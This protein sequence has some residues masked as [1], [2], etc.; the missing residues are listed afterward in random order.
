MHCRVGRKKFL[1]MSLIAT[2][3]LTVVMAPAVVSDDTVAETVASD[4]EIIDSPGHIDVTAGDSTTFSILIVNKSD[5]SR[6]VKIKPL[7][8]SNTDLEVDIDSKDNYKTIGTGDGKCTAHIE[9]TISA[10]SYAHQG[11]YSLN[12]V[13]EHIA[14]DGSAT[15]ESDWLSTELAL[16]VFVKSDLSSANEYNKFLG[17]FANNFD[18]LMGD[19]WFTSLVT[20]LGWMLIGWLV[21]VIAVPI[22]ARIVTKKDDPAREPL[23]KILYRMCHAIIFLNAVGRTLRCLGAT[24]RIIDLTNV[25]FYLVVLVVCI[26]VAWKL[27]KLLIHQMIVKADKTADEVSGRDVDVESLEPLLLYIGEVVLAILAI[28]LVM[29]LLG[30]DF[31]AILMSAGIVSLGISYGARE[32]LGQFFAGIVILITRPFKKGDLVQVGGDPTIFIVRKVNVMFTELANWDNS[33]INQMP[34]NLVTNNKIKNITRETLVTK[35]YVSMEVSYDS[36]LA[37][38]REVMLRAANMNPHVVTDGSVTRPYTRVE[39]FKSSNIEIKMGFYA[40]DINSSYTTAGQVRQT[41]FDFFQKENIS[42]DYDTVI[43][44]MDAPEVA[45]KTVD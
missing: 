42:I 27:Y 9:I 40:D 30:V 7:L 14:G 26:I 24:E 38:V 22:T 1:L 31:A 33:D 17:L 5:E 3:L 25:V 21:M 12:I 2:L 20:F 19:V 18:G 28:F 13:I 6:L 45:A 16:P 10:G 35:F 41:I 8:D 32:V 39:A 43:V 37:K 29:G 11:E 34:N 36:D 44:K 23:K 15:E 4:V